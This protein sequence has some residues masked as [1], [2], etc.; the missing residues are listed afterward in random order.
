[1][2]SFNSK[3]ET[4]KTAQCRFEKKK[5]ELKGYYYYIHKGRQQNHLKHKLCNENLYNYDNFILP[6]F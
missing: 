2:Y 6:Y 5:L 1:M 3:T 4:E